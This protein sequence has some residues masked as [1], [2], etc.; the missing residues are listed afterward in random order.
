MPARLILR[1]F[2]AGVVVASVLVLAGCGGDDNGSDG[3]ASDRDKA[4]AAAQ[5]IYSEPATQRLDLEAGPCISE[6]LPG[7]E[8]WAADVAHDPR[9]PVDDEAANQCQ[10][11]RDGET[12]HFVELT[13]EGELIRAE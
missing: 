3:S 8:D 1:L 9:L 2:S 6:R 12:H 4:I 10:S 5:F 13:P 7:V 11:V